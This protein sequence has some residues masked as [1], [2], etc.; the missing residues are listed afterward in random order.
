MTCLDLGPSAELLWA[1]V[2][3]CAPSP[4]QPAQ[5]SQSGDGTQGGAGLDAR[6]PSLTEAPACTPTP[7]AP[8]PGPP[9]FQIARWFCSNAAQDPCLAGLS[10]PPA[11]DPCPVEHGD[12]KESV[13]R[14]AWDVRPAGTQRSGPPRLCSATLLVSLPRL[15]LPHP[16]A[17]WSRAA[18][19]QTGWSLSTPL[20]P[21]PPGFLHSFPKG[22]ALARPTRMLPPPG[23]SSNCLWSPFNRSSL[24]PGF[25]PVP[26]PML[27]S[28]GHLGLARV[29]GC[30]PV[31]HTSLGSSLW[32]WPLC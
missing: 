20:L 28:C 5:W 24:H 11:R 2:P 4:G 7:L 31:L 9:A 25:L 29:P 6:L 27:S 14:P 1:S 8:A 23:P 3:Q 32:G 26:G 30:L 16:Q 10:P 18:G 19:R 12:R 13:G 21:C 15:C 22:W 17:G